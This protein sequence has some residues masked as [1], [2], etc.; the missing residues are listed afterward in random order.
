MNFIF[1]RL[2]STLIIFFLSIANFC[3][4]AQTSDCAFYV[5]SD[6]SRKKVRH[7]LY[8]LNFV[9]TENIDVTLKINDKAAP[10]T[11]ELI[12]DFEDKSGLPTELGSTL[13]IKFTDG[14]TH[15][16]ITRTKKV[17]TS[18]IYFTLIEPSSKDDRSLINKLSKIEI[19][20]LV[21][22][23]DAKQREIRIPETKAAI[24]R[25]TVLC[26]TDN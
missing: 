20:S 24:I 8:P 15:S 17:K 16:I 18:V 25:K 26:L 19:A 11:V 6:Q 12:F 10:N 5:A 23:A 4:M 22:I 13:S 3:L 1:H 9:V 21:I 7:S 14:T 2:K